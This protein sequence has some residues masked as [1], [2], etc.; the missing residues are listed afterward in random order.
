VSSLSKD[1]LHAVDPLQYGGDWRDV[2]QALLELIENLPRAAVVENHDEYVHA[3]FKSRIFGFVD[4]VE[5]V[6]DDAH[7]VVHIRSAARLGYY[8][9]GVNRQ[10]VEML[11]ARLTS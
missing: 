6:F 1:K 2:K 7:K 8:D 9:F 4:D 3:I 10:R 11:R 5:F